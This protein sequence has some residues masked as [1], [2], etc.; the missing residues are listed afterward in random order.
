MNL[1]ST[2]APRD[3]LNFWQGNVINI[4]RVREFTGLDNTDLARIA[5]VAKSSM[6]TD[7]KAPRQVLEHLANIAN[8]CNLVYEFFNDSV[9][10]KLWLQTANPM[11]GNL[12]PRDMIRYGRFAKLQRF[13]ANAMVEGRAVDEA[14]KGGS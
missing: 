8:I 2:V 6:R 7:S 9:K 3:S 4:E 12:S 13:V 14:Q 1:F 11:L 10:T 5:G